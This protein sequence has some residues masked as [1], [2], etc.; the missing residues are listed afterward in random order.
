MIP[1]QNTENLDVIG[2]FDTRLNKIYS[3][4]NS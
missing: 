3:R 4:I 2:L 1:A